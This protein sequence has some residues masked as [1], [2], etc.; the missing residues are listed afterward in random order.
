[1]SKYIKCPRCE[2]NYIITEEQHC[3]V[4]KAEMRLEGYTLLEEEELEVLCPVCKI[5]T[6]DDGDIICA[7]CALK[8]V[9][10]SASVSD[11]KSAAVTVGEEVVLTA[12]DSDMIDT[13]EGDNIEKELDEAGF[14]EV[15]TDDDTGFVP[16]AKALGIELDEEVEEDEEEFEPTHD[17]DDMDYVSVDEIDDLLD[18]VD[19]D[20]DEE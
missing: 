1:M 4:C 3:K 13:E 10:R 6:L 7:E 2:L 19:D 16:D 8:K 11:K 20:D 17:D 9:E 18:G 12:D 5:N 14:F 15:E